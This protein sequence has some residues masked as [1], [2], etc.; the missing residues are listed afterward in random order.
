MSL[1]NHPREQSRFLQLP[2]ELRD[3]IYEAVLDLETTTPDLVTPGIERHPLTSRKGGSILVLD[4][5]PA[6]SSGSLMRCCRQVRIELSESILHKSASSQGLTSKLDLTVNGSGQILPIWNAIPAPISNIKSVYVNFHVHNRE[7]LDWIGD[8]GPA[9]F[10]QALL[11]L[12]GCFFAYGP[13][14]EDQKSQAPSW[15]EELRLDVAQDDR[16][17]NRSR[18]RSVVGNLTTFLSMVAHSGVVGGRLGKLSL[19]TAGTLVE[20]WDVSKYGD[21]SET[22]REWSAYGWV[23]L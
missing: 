19:Y 18:L 16:C 22:V 2:R 20:R 5:L 1:N 9:H 12:L 3:P 8:G 21:C 11:H 10:T 14:F 23:P 15:I 17:E 13:S 4:D 7:K 6:T